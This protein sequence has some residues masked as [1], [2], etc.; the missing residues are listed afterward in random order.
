M[1]DQYKGKVLR[2]AVDFD[3]TCVENKFPVVGKTLPGAAETIKLL[4]QAGHEVFLWTCRENYTY[5]MYLLQALNWAYEFEI[6]FSGINEDPLNPFLS[7]GGPDG[8]H[9]R[10][11]F[12]DVY[13]DDKNLGGFP[14][15]DWVKEKLL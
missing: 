4:Q 13:I 5:D 1:E 3:G 2:I 15:W 7:L 10:K 11:I 9:Q 12:A 6:E 8:K 14:G